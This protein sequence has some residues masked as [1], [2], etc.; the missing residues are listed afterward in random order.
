MINCLYLVLCLDLFSKPV[1]TKG[2]IKIEDML[3]IKIDS[4][5]E[6][7]NLEQ[8]IKKIL[9]QVKINNIAP[10]YQKIEKEQIQVEQDKLPKIN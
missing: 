3:G 2:S 8:Y 5:P 4:W 9:I 6:E 10:L 1:L 7:N